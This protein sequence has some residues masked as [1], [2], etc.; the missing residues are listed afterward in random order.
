MAVL[1]G[2]LSIDPDRI[3]TMAD[4]ER[5]VGSLP[6]EIHFSGNAEH[7]PEPLLTFLLTEVVAPMVARGAKF[8]RFM[9]NPRLP[10]PMELI[11]APPS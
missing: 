4:A 2:L 10:F 8:E 6:R 11:E 3:K 9:Y 1:L 7:Y 5:L